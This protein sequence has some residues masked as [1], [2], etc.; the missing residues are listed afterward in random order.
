MTARQLWHFTC[1]HSKPGIDQHGE[2][3]PGKVVRERLRH[4]DQPVLPRNRE[5]PWNCDYAWFTDLP[6]LAG[7]LAKWAVV[8][9]P[10][11]Q[12]LTACDR[13]VHRYRV[14]DPDP[15]VWWPV[16]VRLHRLQLVR[17]QLELAPRAMPRHWW[18][19]T[20]PVPVVYDPEETR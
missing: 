14:L 20:V 8:M 1:G 3:W 11:D 18:I 16:G 7:D 2:V 13:T 6:S 4:P 15:C 17:H 12:T 5:L 10:D 19:S 9:H